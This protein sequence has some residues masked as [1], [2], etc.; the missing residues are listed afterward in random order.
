M[1][2]AGG[3]IASTQYP[4]RRA[5]IALPDSPRPGIA[6]FPRELSHVP[7]SVAER[8]NNLVHRNRMPSGGHFAPI[9]EPELLVQDISDFV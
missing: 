1:F 9:K 6:V 4:C 2:I 3:Q 8:H 7:G 5:V